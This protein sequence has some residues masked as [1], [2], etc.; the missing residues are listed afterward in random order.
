MFTILDLINHYLGYFTT[1]SKIKG[2]IYTAVS[3][4]GVWYLVYLA[5][6]FFANGR[7]LRGS[8][9]AAFFVFLLYFVVLNIIYYF[10]KS[11]FKW[12]VSPHIEKILGGPH[13]DEE[14]TKQATMIPANGIY[15]RQNIMTGVVESDTVQQENITLLATEL[16][17]LG[18][19]NNDYGHLGEQAQRQIIAQR[20]VVFANHP[21]TPLP[22]FDMVVMNDT[23]KI[24]GGVNQLQAHDLGTLVMVGMTPTK[25]AL[26]NYRLALSAV[27]VVGGVGHTA[28]RTELTNTERAYKIQVE[29]AYEKKN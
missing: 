14:T 13:V 11:T 23:T 15:Q 19:M 12:D 3:A 9:I 20:D 16:D 6:R 27:L 5:Y 1:S 8:L 26:N 7:W 21:G 22:Y 4:V 24:L 29:V 28:T 25:Q 10:T 17:Q 18:L 2:R